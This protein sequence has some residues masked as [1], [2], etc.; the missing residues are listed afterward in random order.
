MKV[1]DWKRPYSLD[2]EFQS[3]VWVRV[4]FVKIKIS[5]SPKSDN[6]ESIWVQCNHTQHIWQAQSAISRVLSHRRKLWN[7]FQFKLCVTGKFPYLD[8]IYSPFNRLLPRAII[9]AL[10]SMP[11]VHPVICIK[12]RIFDIDWYWT[13]SLLFLVMGTMTPPPPP[14]QPVSLNILCSQ[15]K[16]EEN[17]YLL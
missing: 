12:Y 4:L 16:F 8:H 15:F 11:T 9:N 3:I 10:Y 14:P 17:F 1:I 2:R 7:T 5:G 13:F 6:W